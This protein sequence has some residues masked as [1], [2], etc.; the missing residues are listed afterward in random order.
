M[1]KKLAFLLVFGLAFLAAIG[2]GTK[3]SHRGS[4]ATDGGGEAETAPAPDAEPA[5]ASDPAQTQMPATG[6][7]DI[8]QAPPADPGIDVVR[9]YIDLFYRG[10]LQELFNRFSEEMKQTLTLEQLTGLH[11]QVQKDYGEETEVVGEDFQV[12]G[13]FR[14]FVRW[15]RFDKYDGVIELQWI[16][17][18]DDSIAGFFIRPAKESS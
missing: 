16:L 13:E 3:Q 11:R 1:C 7:V 10:E 15:A 9:S 5:P 14:G 12:K 17:R 2:C 4:P 6:S 18:T 8:V